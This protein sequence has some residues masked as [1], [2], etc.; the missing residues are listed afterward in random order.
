MSIPQQ[1]AQCATAT[2]NHTTI[3]NPSNSTQ[4]AQPITTKILCDLASPSMFNPITAEYANRPLLLPGQ[5]CCHLP[6]RKQEINKLN[7]TLVHVQVTSNTWE[8]ECKLKISGSERAIYVSKPRLGEELTQTS[9][10]RCNPS[11]ITPSFQTM[12]STERN[13]T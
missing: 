10:R 2:L 8:A 6:I 9:N 13:V 4:L 12:P 7:S 1:A 11:I 5:S 3:P